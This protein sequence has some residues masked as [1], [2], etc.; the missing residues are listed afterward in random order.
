MT[1]IRPTLV[2]DA[3]TADQKQVL[4]AWLNDA[5]ASAAFFGAGWIPLHDRE[6]SDSHGE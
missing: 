5:V 1:L 6:G 2:E 4:W 3:I